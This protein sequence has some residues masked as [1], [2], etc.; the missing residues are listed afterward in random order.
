MRDV[1]LSSEST[2]LSVV[3]CSLLSVTALSCMVEQCSEDDFYHSSSRNVFIACEQLFRAGRGVDSTTVAAYLRTMQTGGSGGEDVGVDDALRHAGDPSR[4][5]DYIA[6][7]KDR[8]LRRFA[9]QSLDD[10]G[11][12]LYE[13]HDHKELIEYAEA[14]VFQLRDLHGDKV[15][16]HSSASTLADWF[17]SYLDGGE[18][19][20]DTWP[21]P[22]AS[23]QNQIGGLAPGELAIL[24]G[25]SGD[26]KSVMALQHLEAA[27]LAGARVGYWSLEMPERQIQRRLVA[28]A[29]ISIRKLRDRNLTD[30]DLRKAKRRV[31]D[32]RR[33]DYDVYAGTV[34]VD[35]IRAA[36][37]RHRYDVVI[38]DHLH[39]MNRSE[40]RESLER[41]ARACKNL[42]LDTNCAVL[43]LAQL[44]RRDGF[45]PPTTNQLRGTDVL[46]Q[47]AD[48][49]CFVYRDRDQNVHRMDTGQYIIAKVRDGEADNS[50]PI[51]FHPGVMCFFDVG[52]EI[53]SFGEQ[54]SH[55]GISSRLLVNE[56]ERSHQDQLPGL[57]VGA[58][59]GNGS[60]DSASG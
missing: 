50:H 41:Y 60:A 16:D 49:V 40:E 23:A 44:S 54:S 10:V 8:S 11:R 2:E 14:K 31:E 39:R 21:Y 51:R 57:H 7:L 59:E 33:Y 27:C 58:A 1:G 15:K 55:V 26:G 30:F 53:P 4:I 36:Q 22:L 34:T 12:G 48:T 24:A 28:M 6:I 29:G 13:I 32:L 20:A 52:L 42:A 43:A 46:T 37:M 45:P 47:E 56:L 18:E 19:A 35:Q 5:R 17:E 9:R 25:Y 3:G 38:V